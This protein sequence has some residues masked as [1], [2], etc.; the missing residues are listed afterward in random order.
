[1]KIINRD[2]GSGKTTILI[3]TAYAT[4]ARIVTPTDAMAKFV[5]SEAKKNE[6]DILEPLSIERW[7]N[8]KHL[9]QFCGNDVLID[10]G[11]AIIEEA[12][13]AYLGANV[14]AVTMSVPCIGTEKVVDVSE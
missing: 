7:N 11:E 6:L 1:M 8:A 9:R 10:E 13:K 12:L 14:I 5:A 4:G 3:Y 2:L